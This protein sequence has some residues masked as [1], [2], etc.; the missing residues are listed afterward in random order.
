[1]TTLKSE[2][3]EGWPAGTYMLKYRSGLVS[4][5]ESETDEREIKTVSITLSTDCEIILPRL[6]VENYH[7]LDSSSSSFSYQVGK[8]AMQ[9]EFKGGSSTCIMS[10]SIVKQDLEDG[11]LIEL[12][13]PFEFNGDDTL[14]IETDDSK[15]EGLYKLAYVVENGANPSLRQ[16]LNFEV[17]IVPAAPVCQRRWRFPPAPFSFDSIYV[18]GSEATVIEFNDVD[19]TNCDFSLAVLNV[20]DSE[21]K[22]IDASIGTLVQP[23]L[24]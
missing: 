17:T 24:A 4:E 14:T 5:N 19:V 22:P 15:Y 3:L 6:V 13:P 12:D 23:Q 11:N 7:S 1:M 18:R 20:T 2:N 21:Q 10:V 8:P 16:E 9:V